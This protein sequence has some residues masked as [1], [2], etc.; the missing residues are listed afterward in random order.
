[1][2]STSPGEK[3]PQRGSSTETDKGVQT[4]SRKRNAEALDTALDILT[5]KRRMSKKKAKRA[6]ESS[7]QGQ[8]R[9]L[10]TIFQAF[11]KDGDGHVTR[12]ELAEIM[13]SM[14]KRPLKSKID[15]IFQQA[16]T[17]G[18]GTIELSEFVSFFIGKKQE[19]TATKRELRG[20]HSE[21]NRKTLA[22][23]Y[24][25]FSNEPM[26]GME[27]GKTNAFS[28]FK[29]LIYD[30]ISANLSEQHIK[31]HLNK[32]SFSVVVC[33]RTADF[34]QLLPTVDQAWI[35]SGSSL[36]EHTH[37]TQ[38][39]ASLASFFQQ[40]KGIAIWG[41][42]KRIAHASAAVSHL[43]KLDLSLSNTFFLYTEVKPS[44]IFIDISDSF[45]FIKPERGCMIR[46]MAVWLMHTKLLAIT[47]PTPPPPPPPIATNPV[48]HIEGRETCLELRTGERFDLEQRMTKVLF[49]LGWDTP[50]DLDASILIY[51]HVGKH[52]ETI[53][54]GKLK[55]SHFEIQHSGDT[56]DGALSNGTDGEQIAVNL[57]SLPYTITTLLFV[58]NVF[59]DGRTFSD[60]KDAYVRLVDATNHR[61]QCRYTIKKGLGT[62][63]AVVICKV[64][65]KDNRWHLVSIGEPI[66]R[67]G[68]TPQEV[69]PYVQEFLDNSH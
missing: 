37:P 55:S 13:R 64:Y 47:Q 69:I 52:V 51:D 59:T 38:F 5:E 42:P 61:E 26:S 32:L 22:H 28:G 48:N 12:D 8:R 29:I 20:K 3:Q 39:A 45:K 14:G 56:I 6:F 66:E 62:A 58:A 50:F 18:N 67:G 16:D 2:S 30:P 44:R 27:M 36:E 19:L 24:R 57:A 53:Y 54:Y 65:K 21:K 4:R 34:M 68:R 35:I 7:D 10:K 41:T 31:R 49:G 46:N 23:F 15:R 1:M 63:R 33:S 9:Q 11:D 25:V 40:G 60:V 43:L 17:D